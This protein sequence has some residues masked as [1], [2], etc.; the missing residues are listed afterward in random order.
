MALC[1]LATLVV[2]V[3]ALPS[4]TWPGPDSAPMLALVTTSSVPSDPSSM[5]PL[6]A[7]L[8][9]A[10]RKVPSLTLVLPPWV[11]AW[12]STARPAPVLV[13]PKPSPPSSM[14][15]AKFSPS[16]LTTRPVLPARCS[17]PLSVPL[18]LVLAKVAAWLVTVLPRLTL[19]TRSSVAPAASVT[20]PEPAAV[21]ALICSVPAAT[22]VPPS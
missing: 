9:W 15:P 18:P 17:A 1:P 16:P 6:P 21:S 8:N 11:L 10:R 20:A 13:R 5:A 2:S 4:V 14:G 22:V 12:L 7:A 19:A 3:T